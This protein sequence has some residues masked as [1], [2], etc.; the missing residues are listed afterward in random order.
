MAGARH[1]EGESVFVG[2]ATH[3]G[4]QTP[5]QVY[6]LV[7]GRCDDAGIACLSRVVLPVALGAVQSPALLRRQSGYYPGFHMALVRMEGGAE[8]W[9]GGLEKDP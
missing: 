9:V 8:Q 6:P 5:F 1:W 4:L 3:R 7:D 2:V